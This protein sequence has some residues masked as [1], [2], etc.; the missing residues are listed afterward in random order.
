M[1][2]CS[3]VSLLGFGSCFGVLGGFSLLLLVAE[4]LLEA[5]GFLTMI[6]V[7]PGCGDPSLGTLI[8]LGPWV[9]GTLPG[10]GWN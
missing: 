9:G 10:A 5:E 4:L 6:G 2:S 7:E 8:I 1:A 3:L